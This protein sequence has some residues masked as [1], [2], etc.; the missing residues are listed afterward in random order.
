MNQKNR[1]SLRQIFAVFMASAMVLSFAACSKKE[2]DEDKL[3]MSVPESASVVYL[4]ADPID[5][6][7]WTEAAPENETALKTQDIETTTGG[8]ATLI[9][10]DSNSE[11]VVSSDG[12]TSL[13]TNLVL[14]SA[15]VQLGDGTVEDL[16]EN[17]LYRWTESSGFSS[18]EYTEPQQ[19]EAGRY[20]T[21]L[22]LTSD[23]ST[24][25]QVVI[26]SDL[27]DG[28][29]RI[30]RLWMAIRDTTTEENGEE[31]NAVVDSLISE[32]VT[33]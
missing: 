2:I 7:V 30:D 27:G 24:T 19:I 1:K 11:P 21:H 4:Q 10:L 16:V 26:Y 28:T 9:V 20:M 25:E 6:S 14:N 33:A 13:T 18:V 3:Q 17:E 8:T 12:V 29:A 22:M 31:F 5:P 23:D 32:N 15:S